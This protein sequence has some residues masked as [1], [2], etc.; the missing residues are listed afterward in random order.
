MNCIYGKFAV[1]CKKSSGLRAQSAEQELKLSF[2]SL[3][4]CFSKTGDFLAKHNQ[5]WIHRCLFR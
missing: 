3:I 2:K 5:F 4:E 1:Y